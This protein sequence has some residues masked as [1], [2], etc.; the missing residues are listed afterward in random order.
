MPDETNPPDRPPDDDQRRGRPSPGGGAD[1]PRQN[2]EADVKTD[3][4][5]KDPAAK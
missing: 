5:E 4:G 3:G 2:A 1:A